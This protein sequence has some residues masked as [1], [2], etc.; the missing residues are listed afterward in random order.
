MGVIINHSTFGTAG[1]VN[2]RMTGFEAKGGPF[3]SADLSCHL[4][5]LPFLQG[6]YTVDLW[7]GDGSADLDACLGCLT[8]H[9]EP[10]DI[11]GS[12]RIPFDH[13]GIALL[14]PSWQIEAR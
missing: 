13:M 9:I 1:G 3:V 14:K 7:L 11:Y 12:G 5:E 8:F 2:T 4:Q 6:Q 10:A